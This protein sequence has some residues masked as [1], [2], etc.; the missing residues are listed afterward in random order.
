MSCPVRLVVLVLAFPSCC[1]SMFISSAIFVF[2]GG[3]V[4]GKHLPLLPSSD[5]HSSLA[6]RLAAV[7]SIH[8]MP[9]KPCDRSN[10]AYRS[11]HGQ[12]NHNDHNQ[13]APGQMEE[14]SHEP[15]P[16]NLTLGEDN[17]L[18]CC[19]KQCRIKFTY[20]D[21]AAHF[22]GHENDIPTQDFLVK[23]KVVAK[24]VCPVPK[25]T[26]KPILPKNLLRHLQSEPHYNVLS[27]PC[28]VCG[29]VLTRDDY[30]VRHERSKRH[31]D[32]LAK[33]QKTGH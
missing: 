9:D 16:I 19:V 7:L 27:F 25:C 4:P 2:I 14:P 5:V 15:S 10:D 18:T 17:M 29:I 8:N 22:A 12:E 21:M 20:H 28:L 30:F 33:N 11:L 32:A 6:A 31:L 3:F 26:S 23:G 1:F 24:K 13:Q